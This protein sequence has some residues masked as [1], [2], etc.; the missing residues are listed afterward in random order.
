[1][2]EKI[3]MGGADLPLVWTAE[4]LRA[5][6]L[7]GE[8]VSKEDILAFPE[9]YRDT[10]F[11]FSTWGMPRFEEQ[12]IRSCLPSLR[13]VFYAAGSVQ[14]FAAPFLDA[15]V[16]VFSARAANAIPVAEYTVAQLLLA[17]KGFF[18]ACR[19]LHEGA[20]DWASARALS[21]QYTGNYGATVGIIGCGQIGQ[22][23][24]RQLQ[25]YHLRVLAYDAF[26]TA[27]QLHALGAE[28]VTLEE[29]F[30]VSDV[31]S[32]HLAN[33][34]AT[35]GML[36]G[37]LFG[38]MKPYATFLNTGRGATVRQ[39]ELIATLTARPDLCALLDVADP[40][41]P[42][43]ASP[44]LTLPNVFLT[45]HISGSQSTECARMGAYMA[46]E[47]RAFDAGQATRFAV[48]RE[49]LGTMA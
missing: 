48:T 28:K 34:P 41:P 40:E 15:G 46:E 22:L 35:V 17:N 7:S 12:E 29:L 23:V 19:T 39:D 42:A 36:G 45:P 37:A 9:R 5:A 4:N 13:A 24:I 49:M 16:A 32:N 6:G 30:A 31:I 8:T 21:G 44:L 43:P 20:A 2:N 1:M 26:L 3:L 10:R 27:E 14:S 33:V 18:R 25:G 47:F 11:L 38:S